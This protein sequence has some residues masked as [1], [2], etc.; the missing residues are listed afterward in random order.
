METEIYPKHCICDLRRPDSFTRCATA[1]SFSKSVPSMSRFF[2]SLYFFSSHF[3]LRNKRATIV[4][5][6]SFEFQFYL[7]A[8]RLCMVVLLYARSFSQEQEWHLGGR[9]HG[10]SSLEIH[11]REL[12][13]LLGKRN[14]CCPAPTSFERWLKFQI[15]EMTS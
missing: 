10:L 9:Q 2:K 15:V 11:F 3:H 5:R 4:R 12:L 7:I 6:H 1:V 14:W 8:F 13:Q